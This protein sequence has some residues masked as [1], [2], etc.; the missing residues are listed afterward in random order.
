MQT[1]KALGRHPNEAKAARLDAAMR[2]TTAQAKAKGTREG[3]ATA[4][5]KFGSFLQEMDIP[6]SMLTKQHSR[7]EL[8]SE[9]TDSLHLQIL[10][11]YCMEVTRTHQKA[12]TCRQYASHVNSYWRAKYKLT[13]WP[14]RLFE[15]LKPLTDG[16]LR[17]KDYVARFRDGL[18]GA[19][20]MTIKKTILSWA[21][22]GKRISPRSAHH[23]DDRMAASAIGAL[24]MA[25]GLTFR[26]GEV[27]CPDQ[28]DFEY[29]ASRRLTRNSASVIKGPAGHFDILKLKAPRFKS[30]NKYSGQELTGEI[31]HS[32]PLNWASALIHMKHVDP[33]A[34]ANDFSPEAHADRQITP[35]FRDTRGL[36]RIPGSSLYPAG[37]NPIS[38]RF[39]REHVIRAAV[40][41]R[42][43]WFGTRLPE[44]FGAHSCRIG[45][46]NDYIDAG[47][48]FFECSAA[49]RWTSQSILDYHRLSREKRH[50]WQRR[51]VH[52]SLAAAGRPALLTPEVP[53]PVPDAQ[54][55]ERMRDS[56][57][58]ALA[59]PLPSSMSGPQQLKLTQWLTET[60][61]K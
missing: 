27:T 49:G 54:L 60:R 36:H 24:E 59:T 30:N 11:A 32:D 19:D 2:T 47:G 10:A 39:M 9:E 34:H 31:V 58:R 40:K 55:A 21:R 18:S 42:P 25:Y 3:Y 14:P 22:S 56:V 1:M 8:W 52:T 51:I 4:V 38:V 12:N 61:S 48:S 17:T 50:E 7:H 46:L 20:I 53:R 23:W 28:E 16:L 45:S 13:L 6:I 35:M 15:E 43:D 37:G 29:L 41:A 26:F 5:T 44:T 33:V 57:N